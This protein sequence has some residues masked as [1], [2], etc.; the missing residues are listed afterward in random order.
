MTKNLF[1]SYRDAANAA[2]FEAVGELL[3]IF[4]FVQN[5]T[6]LPTFL[7]FDAATS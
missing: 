1:V 6:L 2:F 5:P 3:N 4:I 7:F